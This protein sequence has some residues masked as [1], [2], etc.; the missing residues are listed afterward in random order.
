MKIGIAISTFTEEKTDNERYQ[1]IDRSFQSLKDYVANSKLNLYIVIVVDGIIPV[2]HQTIISKYDFNVYHRDKNGGVARTKNTSI[3]LILEQNCYIGFLMDDDVLYKPECFEKYIDAMLNGN[4]HHMVYC[5][6]PPIVHPKNEWD[7]FGYIETH[8]N[9]Y[10]LM[11]HGGGGVGCL[12]SFT[13]RLIKK[14]GYFKVM[15]GKY[16]YE[17]INFT[18]RAIFHNVIPFASDIIN[19]INYIDHIGFEPI[20]YNNFKKC[21]SISEDYRKS[22]NAKNRKEWQLNLDKYVECIE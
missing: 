6:M 2:K 21:H 10:P 5:H 19:S 1:I 20:S 4:I 12:L 22:E 7:K 11:K 3:R 17:H 8:I 15:S 9:N 14:I 18:K 16:G 13:P